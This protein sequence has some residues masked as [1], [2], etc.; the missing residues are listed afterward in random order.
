MPQPSSH[1]IIHR[2]R[3]AI[4]YQRPSFADGSFHVGDKVRV[5]TKLRTG[6]VSPNYI[7]A[8][9]EVTE[10]SHNLQRI[11]VCFNNA[12]LPDEFFW[13][14]ELEALHAGSAE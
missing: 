3:P 5:T 12:D 6:T 9:G 10:V 14:D 2:R 8:I 11:D 13:Q 7:G 4:P 1:T